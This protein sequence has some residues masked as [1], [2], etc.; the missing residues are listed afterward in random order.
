MIGVLKWFM[1]KVRKSSIALFLIIFVSTVVLFIAYSR[2]AEKMDVIREILSVPVTVD[3]SQKNNNNL[4]TPSTAG[5]VRDSRYTEKVDVIKEIL[6]VPVTVDSSQKNNNNL[7]TPSTAGLVR[8]IVA[9]NISKQLQNSDNEKNNNEIENEFKKQWL[10]VQKHRVDWKQILAPCANN[11]VLG[12][13][14]PG[15]GKE[16]ETSL[17]TSY[18]DYIDVRPAGQFSRFYIRTKTK[19]GRNKTIGGDFWKVNNFLTI[20]LKVSIFICK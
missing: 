5:L 3:G 14:L 2:Y 13:T 4:F 15:W 12:Q 19:D 16:N 6:S 20:V 11:T 7:F 8:D 18:F 17:K 9:P 1:R 10:R